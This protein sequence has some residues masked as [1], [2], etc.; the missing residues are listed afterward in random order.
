MTGRDSA[1]AARLAAFEAD[2]C[3]Q[4]GVDLKA[5]TEPVQ[6]AAHMKVKRLWQV[7][8]DN[9]VLGLAIGEHDRQSARS[10]ESTLVKVAIRGENRA[11]VIRCPQRTNA[12][13]LAA[14]VARVLGRN[15][16][17]MLRI[18]QKEVELNE[19]TVAQALKLVASKDLHALV[20]VA[21]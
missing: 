17:L 16:R 2:I 20:V 21:D 7:R 10:A 11:S 14:L 1:A 12:R 15:T 18:P 6:K 4:H 9:A 19:Q 5:F 3:R 13:D 8:E